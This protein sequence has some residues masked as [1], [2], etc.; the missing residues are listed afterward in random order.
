M[1]KPQPRQGKSD[2][3]PVQLHPQ[4]HAVRYRRR[5]AAQRLPGDG[6]GV[7]QHV[8]GDAM[9]RL[10]VLDRRGRGQLALAS[11][12]KSQFLLIW[13]SRT[14]KCSQWIVNQ[15][16]SVILQVKLLVEMQQMTTTIGEQNGSRCQDN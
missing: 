15:F 1:P 7:R 2:R 8:A 11:R 5:G 13:Y 16:S 9:H 12:H 4:R 3:D 6:V 10:P 14:K